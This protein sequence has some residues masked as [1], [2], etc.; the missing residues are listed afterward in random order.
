MVRLFF[1][2]ILFLFLPVASLSA[3][4]TTADIALLKVVPDKSQ[5]EM[6]KFLSVRIIY[7]GDSVPDSSSHDLWF[8]D[9][10]VEHRETETE[11]LPNALIQFTEYLRLYPRSSGNKTLG[12]IAMGGAFAQPVSIKVLPVIRKGIDGTPYWQALPESIWQGETIKVS[13]TQNLLH[14]SNQ[15][16]A[17]DVVFPG[18]YVQS[19][20]QEVWLK[21]DIKKVQ[22]NWMITAN[23]Q[24]VFQLDLPAIVQRGRGRW[25]FYLPR[26]VLEVKPLPAYLPATVPVGQLSIETGLSYKGDQP[27]WWVELRNKGQLPEEI[28]GIRKQLSALTGLDAELV[29]QLSDTY[30]SI[31]QAGPDEDGFPSQRGFIQRYQIPVPEWTWGFTEGPEISAAY[32]SVQ[33]GHTKIIKKHLP[34]VWHISKPWLSVFF[35]LFC[36]VLLLLLYGLNKGLKNIMAWRHYRHLLSQT[37]QAHELRKLLLLQGDFLTLDAWA[38]DGFVQQEAKNNIARQLN[39]LCY[40]QTSPHSLDII[41]QQLIAL[42]SWKYWLVIKQKM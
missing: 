35:V 4:E 17:E 20:E 27:F 2:F 5:V 41:K 3:L 11:T 24:G 13:I 7:I 42:Y 38:A 1:L 28:Y 29:E 32:F 36:L 40:A 15:V 33:A 31:K 39:A 9:F 25:R 12:S 34:A 6:G 23:K 26:A 14:P 37:H 16:I 18:F 8:E 30:L 21:N 10:F 19:T 22:L